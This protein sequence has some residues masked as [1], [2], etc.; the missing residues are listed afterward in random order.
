MKIVVTRNY[1]KISEV[2]ITHEMVG[3]I[4]IPGNYDLIFLYHINTSTMTKT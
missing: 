3:I 4:V 2:E 1:H